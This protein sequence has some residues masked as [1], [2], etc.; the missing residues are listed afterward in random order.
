MAAENRALPDQTAS[1]VEEQS[2]T[3][4]EANFQHNHKIKMAKTTTLSRSNFAI[5]IAVIYQAMLSL[6]TTL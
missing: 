6:V 3:K 2:P 5:V 4:N 1:F